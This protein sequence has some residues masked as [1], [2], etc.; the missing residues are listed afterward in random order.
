M[1][2]TVVRRANLSSEPLPRC[3]QFSRSQPAL[4]LCVPREC[5]LP[6]V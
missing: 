5:P 2:L 4:S 6:L 1:G 3:H